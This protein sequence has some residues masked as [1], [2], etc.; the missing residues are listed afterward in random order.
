MF[1]QSAAMLAIV[2]ILTV[3]QLESNFLDVLIGSGLVKQP[4]VM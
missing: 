2:K 4:F 1:L 3:L